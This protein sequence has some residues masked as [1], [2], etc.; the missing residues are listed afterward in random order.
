MTEE[1][2]D[3]IIDAIFDAFGSCNIPIM[4]RMTLFARVQ[5]IIYSEVKQKE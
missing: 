2:A 4:D 1:T 3:R 5:N